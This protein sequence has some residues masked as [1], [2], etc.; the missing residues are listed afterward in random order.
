MSSAAPVESIKDTHKKSTRRGYTRVVEPESFEAEN[1]Y[2]PRVLNAT[3]HPVVAS[4]LNMGNERI[5]T[6]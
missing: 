5:I 2:Y 3:I 6:R 1:H 4:F